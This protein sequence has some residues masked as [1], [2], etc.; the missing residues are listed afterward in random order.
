MKHY[1]YEEI[2]LYLDGEMPP[3][4][5]SLLEDHILV[6]KECAEK[7]ERAK[8]L[9]QEIKSEEENPPVDIASLVMAKIDR[10]RKILPVIYGIFILLVAILTVPVFFGLDRAI[11]F[12]YI[13]LDY[14]NKIYLVA[15][16][17]LSYLFSLKIP[18]WVFAGAVL[19]LFPVYFALRKIWRNT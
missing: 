1:N 6:C 9:Y 5:R 19:M 2:Y 4:E 14:F 12:Y 7:L 8:V 3:M 11:F 17:G 16:A 15:R 13:I 10:K 18:A